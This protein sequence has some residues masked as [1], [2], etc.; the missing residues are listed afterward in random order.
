MEKNIRLQKRDIELLIFLGRYKIM[1]L[2][3]TKNIYGTITY[4]EKRVVALVKNKYIK[5]L[6]HRYIILGTKGKEYL[7]ENGYEIK[8]HCRNKN[9]IERLKVISDIACCFMMEDNEFIPSWEM[10]NRNEPTS[11]SRRYIGKLIQ[12]EIE[13]LVYAI[14]GDKNDKYITLIYYD[15]RKEDS[16]RMNIMI[17]TNNIEKILNNKK[18]FVFSGDSTVIIPYNE[19]GKYLLRN[20]HKIRKGMYIRLTKL[21]GAE[22]TD[23]KYADLKIDDN[24]YITIMPL[25]NM[26]KI[27][28]LYSLLGENKMIKV[29]ILG[30]EE[31]KEIITKFLDICDYKSLSRE[32]IQTI[33]EEIKDEL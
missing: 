8:E 4:Q 3:N 7:R 9:N 13:Y 5:R 21:Y 12:Y 31:N 25:I 33:A 14:Y 16:N 6:K 15:I 26:Q 27:G 17:F 22:L 20:N 29:Y 19:Y 11:D 30:T 10:K 1:S 28:P 23:F 18:S 32:K 2:D 24:K